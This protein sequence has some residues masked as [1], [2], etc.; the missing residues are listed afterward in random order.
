MSDY[1]SAADAGSGASSPTVPGGAPLRNP[2]EFTPRISLIEH[3]IRRWWIILAGIA[4]GL[5]VALVYL[6]TATPLYTATTLLSLD[7]PL[8]G[9]EIQPDVFFREQRDLILSTP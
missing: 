2:I 6:L 7:H 1:A 3:I 4:V 8:V 5:I 9:V